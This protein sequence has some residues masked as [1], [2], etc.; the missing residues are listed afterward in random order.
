MGIKI[1]AERFPEQ[2]ILTRCT[3]NIVTIRLYKTKHSKQD[4]SGK[5]TLPAPFFMSTFDTLIRKC[6]LCCIQVFMLANQ[7]SFAE[8][9]PCS[10]STVHRVG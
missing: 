2:N 1:F 8:V 5:K 4:H 6:C 10:L 3:A 9:R 7:V